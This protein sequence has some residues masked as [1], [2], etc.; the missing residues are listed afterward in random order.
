MESSCKRVHDHYWEETKVQRPA[1]MA[2]FGE[3][4]GYV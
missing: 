2:S 4:E 1:Q 3:R